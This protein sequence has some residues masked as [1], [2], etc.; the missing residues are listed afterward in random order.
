M[1]AIEENAQAAVPGFIRAYA[2]PYPVGYNDIVLVSDFL[3]YPRTQ[4]LHM[5]VIVFIDRQGNILAQYEAG[6]PFMETNPEQN[7]RTMI[8]GITKGTINVESVRKEWAAQRRSAAEEGRTR[9]QDRHSQE[10]DLE[11]SDHL[12][13]Q[14]LHSPHC[15]A[16]VRAVPPPRPPASA[17]AD[18]STLPASIPASAD[19]ASKM[20]GGS[21]SVAMKTALRLRGEAL[22][23]ARATR[24]GCRG[25]GAA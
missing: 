19:T 25:R 9:C 1:S 22:R 23:D 12:I 18:F 21:A 6:E 10:V 5:P 7:L 16:P 4:V 2:P 14:R 20:D 17:S 24:R 11:L 13:E 3:E 15:L 8:Q